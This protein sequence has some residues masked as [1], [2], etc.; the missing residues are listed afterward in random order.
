[1]LTLLIL[2]KKGPTH[3]IDVYLQPL[4]AELKE[5]WSTGAVTYNSYSKIIFTMKAIL[6]WA[7]HDFPAYGHLSGCR[8]AGKFG[9]PMYSESTYLVWLKHV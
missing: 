2:G 5:L 8:T 9:C 1:M 6:L 7:I 4:V 3:N